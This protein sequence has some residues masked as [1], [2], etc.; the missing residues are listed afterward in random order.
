ML[1]MGVEPRGA[2]GAG[3]GTGMVNSEPLGAHH[4]VYVMRHGRHRNGVLKTVAVRG[5]GG[6]GNRFREWLQACAAEEDGTVEHPVTVEVAYAGESEVV[7]TTRRLI[8]STTARDRQDDGEKS[9]ELVTFRPALSCEEDDDPPWVNWPSWHDPGWLPGTPAR[10]ADHGGGDKAV[11]DQTEPPQFTLRE[12]EDGDTVLLGAYGTS[13]DS[14]DA[15]RTWLDGDDES[16]K[17][18]S[19][20]FVG[21]DPVAS[22]VAGQLAGPVALAHGELACLQRRESPRRGRPPYR[23]L[24]TAAA[25]DREDLKAIQDKVKSKI[26]T[27]G[28][29]GTVITGLLVFLLKDQLDVMSWLSWSA[30]LAFLGAA[31][32]Y[33]VALFYYDSLSMPSRFWA[34]SPRLT[35]GPS[36]TA[37]DRKGGRTALRLAFA[38]VSGAVLTT[39]LALYWLFRSIADSWPAA[40]VVTGMAMAVITVT[41]GTAVHNRLV[42]WVSRARQPLLLRPPTSNTR[43]LH[44]T[45][46]HVWNWVF[47]PATV[48]AGIGVALLMGHLAVDPAA[49]V[50]VQPAHVAGA[51]TYG[52]LLVTYCHAR[53]PK[54]GATD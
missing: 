53:A 21:N 25:H 2:S 27:A 14:M 31:L 9:T 43:M 3:R 37:V 52:L 17:R 40:T 44:A 30:L 7:A 36:A 11:S 46:V 19:R 50:I 33:F 26:S 45:M 38:T 12:Q 32:L 16:R 49:N 1:G 6:V 51:L 48:L 41:G 28:A 5:I 20:L 47:L 39:A 35:T 4:Y 10:G 54:H 23:L 29:L 22:R 24:W 15:I 18:G 13:A 42:A 8:I 34:P